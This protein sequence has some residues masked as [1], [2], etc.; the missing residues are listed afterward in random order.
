MTACT[1][2]PEEKQIK[3]PY[4]PHPL[5]QD[6]FGY[7]ICEE[8]KCKQQIIPMIDLAIA[9]ILVP[10]QDKPH[11]TKSIKM[12]VVR[13]TNCSRDYTKPELEKLTKK[14]KMLRAVK[15]T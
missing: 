11:R 12:Q 10:L 14:K 8:K 6:G 4:I 15:I 1:G 3:L 9:T 7:F 13:C 2:D 5:L